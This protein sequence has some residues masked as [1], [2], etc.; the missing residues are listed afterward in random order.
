MDANAPGQDIFVTSDKRRINLSADWFN[1]KAWPMNIGSYQEFVLRVIVPQ[2][3][4]KSAH[5]KEVYPKGF[6]WFLKKLVTPEVI[7]HMLRECGA[8]LGG[9]KRMLDIGTGPAIIPRAFKLL[10]VCDEAYGVDIQDRSGD[11]PDPQ[12]M[13]LLNFMQN[14]L[15]EDSHGSLTTELLKRG[16]SLTAWTTPYGLLINADLSK[17]FSLDDYRT[18]HFLDYELTGEPFDLIV[19]Y[20]GMCY[21]DM[22]DYFEKIVNMLS[23]GGIH[24]V[25]DTNYYHVYGESLELPMDAP[26]LHARVRK[27]DLFRYYQEKRPKLFPYIEQGFFTKNTHYTVRDVIHCARQHGLKLLGYRRSYRE[28]ELETFQYSSGDNLKFAAKT[29][30]EDCRVLN[31]QVELV[32]FLTQNWTAVFQKDGA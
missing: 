30:L 24:Y 6:G 10:G 14:N 9:V 26:W 31:P 17:N 8:D 7:Y 22:D 4:D 3:S 29:V 16:D 13:Q 23:P 19:T 20:T 25:M 27:E 21:F 11:L 32:D 28:S 2:V 18:C 12:F 15:L 5:Q 1:A